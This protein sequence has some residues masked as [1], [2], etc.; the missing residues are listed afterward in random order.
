MFCTGPTR[1]AKAG[2]QTNEPTKE[3]LLSFVLL[4]SPLASVSTISKGPTLSSL[5]EHRLHVDLLQVVLQRAQQKDHVR[6][7]TWPSTYTVIAK[8]N[9]YVNTCVY[10]NILHVTCG[11]Q[12]WSK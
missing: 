6:L 8:N 10:I 1:L 11:L 3:G 4:E 2:Q 5:S 7:H 9:C 12:F